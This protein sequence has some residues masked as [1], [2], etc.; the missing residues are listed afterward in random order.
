MGRFDMFV[1]HLKCPICGIFSEADIPTKIREN[2]DG[3]YLKVGD[4]LNVSYMLANAADYDTLEIPQSSDPVYLLDVWNCPNGHGYNWAQ[5]IVK[6]GII[7]D[8]SAVPKSR[9]ILE[10]THFINEECVC[11]LASDAGYDQISDADLQP[12]ERAKLIFFVTSLE[13]NE[14]VRLRA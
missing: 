10:R 8:I 4:L 14:E 6:D 13:N 1:G 5:I 7:Q 12:N 11:G 9:E 2:P 3:S